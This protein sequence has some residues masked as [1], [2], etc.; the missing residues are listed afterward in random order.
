MDIS[1]DDKISPNTVN[2]HEDMPYTWKQSLNDVSLDV[3]VP[4]NARGKNIICKIAKKNLFFSVFGEVIFEGELF[5]N[6][7]TDGS[8]WTKDGNVVTIELE[9]R[10]KMEWWKCVI[11]GHP[12]IDT[13]KIKPEN[14][15]ISDLDSETRSMVEK[16]MFDQQQ[17]ERG[18]PTSDQLIQQQKLKNFMDQHPEY[19]FSNA[20]IG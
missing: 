9:K 8:T 7:F 19:D 18:L 1:D 15:K 5:N 2:S 3:V 17:Q 4:D 14:S 6:V 20:K 16:M 11:I 12:E 13:Q 10:N